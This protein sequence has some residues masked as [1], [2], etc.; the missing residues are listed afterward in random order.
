MAGAPYGEVLS[1]TYKRDT[2]SARSDNTANDDLTRY[3]DN[4]YENIETD[5]A[6]VDQL[7]NN[8]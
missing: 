1:N 3:I 6:D 8:C 5:P 7:D 4:T 2:A